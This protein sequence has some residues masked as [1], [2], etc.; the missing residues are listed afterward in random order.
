MVS[1]ISIN[2]DKTELPATKGFTI[3]HCRLW[4][5]NH[6]SC[7]KD[8]ALIEIGVYDYGLG[9]SGKMYGQSYANEE[10]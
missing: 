6:A 10:K 3:V 4:N 9:L 5:I 8:A 1:I 2:V 7:F